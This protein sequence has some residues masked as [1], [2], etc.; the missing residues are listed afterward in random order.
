MR[1]FGFDLITTGQFMGSLI[2]I[3]GVAGVFA[4]GWLADRLGHADHGW[5]ARIPAIAWAITLPTFAL[6]L[7]SPSPGARL[8]AAADPERRST[9][10]GWDR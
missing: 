6:A 3:G 8:A 5:Y 1:S 9:S 2:L 10:C 7:M 4:G